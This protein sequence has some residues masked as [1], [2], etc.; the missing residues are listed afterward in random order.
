MNANGVTSMTKHQDQFMHGLTDLQFPAMITTPVQSKIT[1][2]M[3]TVLV[4]HT[5]AN[6]RTRSPVVYSV[7]NAM[8]MEHVR[9]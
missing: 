3:A 5:A 7:L 8:V 9:M 4:A 6:Y 1:V 2:K